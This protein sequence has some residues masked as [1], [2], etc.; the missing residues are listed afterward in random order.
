MTQRGKN[1]RRK[2]ENIPQYPLIDSHSEIQKKSLGQ[3][4]LFQN[5]EEAL[6]KKLMCCETFKPLKTG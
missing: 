3:I 2:R 1:N 5:P 6:R 4:T